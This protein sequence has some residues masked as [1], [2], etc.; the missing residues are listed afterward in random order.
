MWEIVYWDLSTHGRGTVQVQAERRGVG[1]MNRFS[2]A[3]LKMFM[4]ESWRE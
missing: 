4:G 3:M 1:M 2:G